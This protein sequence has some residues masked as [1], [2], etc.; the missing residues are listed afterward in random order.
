MTINKSQEQTFAHVGIYLDEPV[1]S[2]GQLYV[3]LSR[4]RKPNHVKIYTKTSGIQGKLLNNK[5]ASHRMLFIKR[6]ADLA[7]LAEE[8]TSED[9]VIDICKKNKNSPYHEEEF[10]KG[11]LDVIVQEREREIAQAELVRKERETKRAHELEKLKIASAPKTVSLNYTRSEG[12]GNRREIKHLMQKFDSQNTDI[13]LYLTLFERQARTAGIEEEEWVSQLIS[14][15]PLDLAQI[16]IKEPEEQMRDHNRVRPEHFTGEVVL[17]K[18]PLVSEFIC[19]PLAKVELQ[20]PE[21]GCVITKAAVIDVQL[22]SGWY[23]LSNKT[24]ELILEAKRKPNLNAVITRSQTNQTDKKDLSQRSEREGTVATTK[25]PEAIISHDPY[26]LTLP[27]AEK[28]RERIVEVSSEELREAQ[29]GCSTLQACFLQAERGN[30]DFRVE[31]EMLFR[32]SKDHFGNV[33]LQVVILQVY[34]DKILA[35]CHEGISSH[36][37]VRKTKDRLLKH[38]FW[39]NCINPLTPSGP[40]NL[41]T[42]VYGGF[43]D[44]WIREMDSS[45]FSLFLLTVGDRKRTGA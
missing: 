45:A 43:V 30:F 7:R 17:V 9:R 36:L 21:F 20:S 37:G 23:L 28:I 12:S 32:E 1:L 22:D 27:P 35:L 8:I 39:P 42:F 5:N 38:Y 14:L 15:L 24:Y 41:T 6:K 44:I 18:Q 2:H 13:S 33:S 25:E 34:R 26:S 29:R 11:Q 31:G 3:A 40:Q 16:I 4:S 10:A 19:V